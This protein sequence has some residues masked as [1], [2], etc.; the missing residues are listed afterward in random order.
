MAISE[1]KQAEICFGILCLYDKLSENINKYVNSGDKN[2][3]DK[4]EDEYNDLYCKRRI[5]DD[6]FISNII[7]NIN[8]REIIKKI[9]NIYSSNG[10][11]FKTNH[12]V[13]RTLQTERVK[14]VYSR[15][16]LTPNT[17]ESSQKLLALEGKRMI[18]P[19]DIA[20]GVSELPHNMTVN[21]MLKVSKV[22]QSA[23]SYENAAKRLEEDHGIK[24][25]PVTIMN[26]TNEVGRIAFNNEMGQ[27]EKCFDYL[28]SGNLSFPEK[29][30]DG[31]FYIETDG[32]YVNTRKQLDTLE[33]SWH[34]NKLGL[35]FT[36]HSKKM[37][38]MRAK[39][40]QKRNNHYGVERPRFQITEKDY[41]SYVG[42]VEEFKKLLFNCAMRNGYG[43]YKETVL[44]SDGAT[45]IRNMKEELFCDAQQILDYYHLSEKVWALGR[46]YFKVND[47]AVSQNSKRKEDISKHPNYAKCKA[48][49]DNICEELLKSNIDYVLEDII[50]KEKI[51]KNSKLS[52]YI[53]NNI[54]SIDYKCYL[55][56][57]YAI[58]S[59]AIESGNKVVLQRRLD[60]PGMRW[61]V[62]SAQYMVTLKAKDES[63]KWY[64][65]V[66]I[67][68]RKYYNLDT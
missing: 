16:C 43:S 50:K 67:P 5:Y 37:V 47:P 46:C 60:G 13:E 30:K 25:D 15:Y 36:S 40:T 27:A 19:L 42:S 4:I 2:I 18:Y 32:A 9:R 57:G 53:K 55:K 24:L 48:W 56:K 41:T 31:I 34:E 35:V 45:W 68:V 51:L 6:E 33:S 23:Y 8:E 29:K 11:T 28:K 54:N 66:V 10:I 52:T 58:G 17:A 20:L 62:E 7:K 12:K 61:L 63:R 64:S 39:S 3:I 22:A 49:A 65:D 44:I 26:V 1:T 38:K 59:G 21:A 14:V